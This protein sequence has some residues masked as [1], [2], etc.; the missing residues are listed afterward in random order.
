MLASPRNS[1]RYPPNTL[2]NKDILSCLGLARSLLT[3]PIQVHPRGRPVVSVTS[4]VTASASY[5]NAP[6]KAALPDTSQLASNFASLVDNN[7]PSDSANLLPPAQEPPPPPPHRSA[8][9]NSAP[10][11]TAPSNNNSQAS[12][13]ASQ[14]QANNPPANN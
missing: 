6:P 14:N 5:Q 12:S 1:S 9:D 7:L 13:A 2:K 3:L 11:R 10:S 8:N 4:D